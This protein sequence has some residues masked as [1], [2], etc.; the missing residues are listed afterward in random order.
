MQALKILLAEDNPV[1]QKVATA[2]LAK[3]GHAVTVAKDGFDAVAA[4]LDGSFDLVLMDVQMPGLDGFEAT[5]RIRA[6]P[7]TAGKLPIIA[8]TAN[9]LKGDDERC[10]AAGMDDYVSKPIQP[11]A[12]YAAL[13]RCVAARAAGGVRLDHGALDRLAEQVGEE[14]MIELVRDYADNASGP[15]LDSLKTAAASGDVAGVNRWAHDIKSL[16]ATFGLVDVASL[17][18]TVEIAAREGRVTDAT[19]RVPE[20]DE[21]LRAGITLLRAMYPAAFV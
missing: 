6:L 16:S 21:R 3:Q 11:Q 13:E 2:L 8:M 5:A 1:N 18:L 7:G 4:I 20:L 19:S 10:L 15:Y 17:A 9:A 14:A 12:L